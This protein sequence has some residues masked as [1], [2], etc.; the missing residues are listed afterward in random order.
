MGFLARGALARTIL[1]AIFALAT[2]ERLPGLRLGGV[3]SGRAEF[4]NV[5]H[6]WD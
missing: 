6:A 3:C 5:E 2:R 4:G 1:E